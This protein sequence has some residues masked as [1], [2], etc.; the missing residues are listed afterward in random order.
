MYNQLTGLLDKQ[1]SK[2]KTSHVVNLIFMAHRGTAKALWDL[3]VCISIRVPQ[4]K[5]KLF[6]TECPYS[7]QNVVQ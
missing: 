1:T 4:G 7:K 2:T 3:I 6:K 5:L